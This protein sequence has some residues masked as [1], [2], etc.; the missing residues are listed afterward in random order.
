LRIEAKEKENL[1]SML[2]ELEM[3]LV[4]GG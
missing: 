3:K 4:N 1:E 2:K